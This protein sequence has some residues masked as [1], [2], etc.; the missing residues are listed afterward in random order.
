VFLVNDLYRLSVFT[1]PEPIFLAAAGGVGSTLGGLVTFSSFVYD[2]KNAP[3]DVTTFLALV[4][5][6][7]EDLKYA[8]D[9]RDKHLEQLQETPAELKRLDDIVRDA[10]ECILD[11][12]RLLEKCRKEAHGGKVPLLGRM[13]FVLGDSTAFLR[14]TGNL[15]QQHAAINVEIIHLRTLSALKPITDLAP[16]MTFENSDLLSLNG[17]NRS[18]YGLPILDG[19]GTSA[20]LSNISI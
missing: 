19:G 14:R 4:A 20:P 12:A 1:M 10:N 11:I 3:A 8:V 16:N 9:L 2:L 18:S 5:R 15:Q 7:D 13:R 6:V 17:R